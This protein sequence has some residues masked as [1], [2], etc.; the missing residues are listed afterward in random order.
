MVVRSR[1]GGIDSLKALGVYF[2][3]LVLRHKK[4]ADTHQLIRSGAALDARGEKSLTEVLGHLC[5]EPGEVA[6]RVRVPARFGKPFSHARLSTVGIFAT[7]VLDE[8]VVA[9]LRNLLP[10]TSPTIPQRPLSAS[11]SISTT[12]MAYTD[13]FG[14]PTCTCKKSK[15]RSDRAKRGPQDRTT[16]PLRTLQ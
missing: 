13:K 7:T 1:G 2:R 11:W 10:G 16:T 12:S 5:R 3:Q 9:K 4:N 15:I 14:E 6:P 8:I